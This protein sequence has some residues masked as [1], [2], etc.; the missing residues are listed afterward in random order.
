MHPA[1][2][3]AA[4]AAFPFVPAMHR[5]DGMLPHHQ[6]LLADLCQCRSGGRRTRFTHRAVPGVDLKISR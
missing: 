2:L 4:E 6:L 3:R 5:E 1:W